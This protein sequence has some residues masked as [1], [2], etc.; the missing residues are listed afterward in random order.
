M[1]KEQKEIIEA[2]STVNNFRYD[3]WEKKDN[4][5]LNRR[6]SPIPTKYVDLNMNLNEK[7]EG[8]NTVLMS[9]KEA[10]MNSNYSILTVKDPYSIKQVQK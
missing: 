9:T 3:P 8:P 7:Q 6:N 10:F 4:V 1:V 5:A 2:T